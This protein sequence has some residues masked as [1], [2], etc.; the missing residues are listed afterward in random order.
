MI[1]EQYLGLISRSDEDKLQLIGELLFDVMGD[2][3]EEDPA[4]VALM[5]SRLEEYRNNPDQVSP[6]ADVKERLLALR[7]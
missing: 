6:W 1:A 2:S 3:A 7:K 4:I 5:E